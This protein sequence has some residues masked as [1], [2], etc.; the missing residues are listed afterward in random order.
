M[1]GKREGERDGDDER[2]REKGV[3]RKRRGRVE[4]R[5]RGKWIDT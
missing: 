1:K 4:G 3:K 2:F 5:G